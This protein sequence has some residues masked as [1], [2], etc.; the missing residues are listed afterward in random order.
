MTIA[1]RVAQKVAIKVEPTMPVGFF[2][3]LIARML[4][5][6]AGTS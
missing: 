5:A 1:D 2:E 6:V 3:P 4:I